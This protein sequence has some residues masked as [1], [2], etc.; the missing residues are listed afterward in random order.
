M[1]SMQYRSRCIHHAAAL[2]IRHVI[3]VTAK[4][5]NVS[6][7]RILYA[8][9]I[10]FSES[11]RHDYTYALACVSS[12]GFEWIGKDARHIQKEYDI[13]LKQS[14]ASNINDINSLASY[15]SLR[16]GL[17]CLIENR[18]R[19]LPPARMIRLTPAVFWNHLKGLWMSSRDI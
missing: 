6:Y 1:P 8:C 19:P 17:R 2:G 9:V 7:G 18:K 16:N 13:L 5:G 10:E 11:I 3:Y 12:V 14:H 15:Y 4:S